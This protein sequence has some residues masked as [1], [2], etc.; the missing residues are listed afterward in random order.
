MQRI[1]SCCFFFGGFVCFVID[2]VFLKITW[3]AQCANRSL[4]STCYF[5]S[6]F[7]LPKFQLLSSLCEEQAQRGEFAHCHIIYWLRAFNPKAIE[8][9]WWHSATIVPFLT[10]A[11][12]G[13]FL[14]LTETEQ[15]CKILSWCCKI[16]RLKNISIL[17]SWYNLHKLSFEDEKVD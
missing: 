12:G 8:E 14:S 13:G 5:I 3:L 7:D 11:L 6:H 16:K 15:A 10:W 9:Q 17:I 4:I 1:S 2:W